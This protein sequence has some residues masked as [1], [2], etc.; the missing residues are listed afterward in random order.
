MTIK[1]IEAE[2][3]PPGGKLSRTIIILPKANLQYKYSIRFKGKNNY[4][5]STLSA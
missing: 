2:I 5:I 3:N 4:E 1:Q